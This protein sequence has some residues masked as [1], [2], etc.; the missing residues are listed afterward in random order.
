MTGMMVM[1]SED[2]V[3]MLVMI[4]TMIMVMMIMVMMMMIERM[5]RLVMMNNDDVDDD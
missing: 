2:G 4:M 3:M 1:K 5:K